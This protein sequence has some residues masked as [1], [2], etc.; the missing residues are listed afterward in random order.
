M[1]PLAMP[2]GAQSDSQRQ[3]MSGVRASL[4]PLGAGGR[5]ARCGEGLLLEARLLGRGPITQKMNVLFVHLPASRY[6]TLLS[7]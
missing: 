1:K 3:E 5:A 4:R 6:V 2:A 7:T